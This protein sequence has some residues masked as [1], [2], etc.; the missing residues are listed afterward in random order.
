M[1]NLHEG[2][3]G[4]AVTLPEGHRRAVPAF[5]G[6]D[7]SLISNGVALNG[8]LSPQAAQV[9]RIHKDD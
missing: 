5:P 7:D 6:V 3:A 2:G 8:H 1:T 4:V 9:H